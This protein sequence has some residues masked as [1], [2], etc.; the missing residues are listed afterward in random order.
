MKYPFLVE[1]IFHNVVMA[2]SRTDAE[3]E[4]RCAIDPNEP[5]VCHISEITSVH[6]VPARW[7]DRPPLCAD[8]SRTCRQIMEAPE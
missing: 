5:D 2:E 4:G 3:R 7:R 8:D 6:Y 1:H